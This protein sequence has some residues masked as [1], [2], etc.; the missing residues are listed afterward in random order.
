MNFTPVWS[1]LSV[2]LGFVIAWLVPSEMKNGRR[3][4]IGGSIAIAIPA[5]FLLTGWHAALLS[6]GLILGGF[7]GILVVGMTGM[8]TPLPVILLGIVAGVL[9]GSRWRIEGRPWW[10]LPI[11]AAIVLAILLI[12]QTI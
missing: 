5:F 12:P 6:A 9:A 8:F 4:I 1:I 10:H 11:A 2:L 7:F 3:W